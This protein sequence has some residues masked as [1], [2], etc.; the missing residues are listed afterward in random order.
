[1]G[2]KCKIEILIL[3][4]VFL[5]WPV[6]AAGK[7]KSTTD[8]KA[9]EAKQA[10]NNAETIRLKARSV[11]GEWR[12]TGRYIKKAQAAFKAGAYEKAINFAQ[13]AHEQG[14]AGYS[15]AMSQQEL[16]LPSYLKQ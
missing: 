2:V 4:V 15:Q 16:Q 11:D 8:R 3:V 13:Q 10:I 9:M 12:D 7:E 5:S 6:L 1:M 14:E